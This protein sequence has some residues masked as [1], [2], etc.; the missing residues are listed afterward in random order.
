MIH[1][2][3]DFR[4]DEVPDISLSVKEITTLAYLILQNGPCF[5]NE[6]SEILSEI[7]EYDA[8][9]VKNILRRL[10]KKVG[11]LIKFETDGYRIIVEDRPNTDVEVVQILVDSLI[12]END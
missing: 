5:F 11:A 3:G 9:Y 8:N 4:I 1:L 7:S 10:S 2:L 12:D 6:M